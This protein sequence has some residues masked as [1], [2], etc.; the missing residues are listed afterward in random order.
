M[1]SPS[2]PTKTG[3]D[4]VRDNRYM[5][6]GGKDKS[7]VMWDMKVERSPYEIK[8]IEEEVLWFKCSPDHK[9]L[10]FNQNRSSF[11]V[12]IEKSFS[13]LYKGKLRYPALINP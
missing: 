7:V 13:F 9:K 11:M 4:F 3:I 6:S 8:L 12:W 2:T 1:A 5:I 10:Y